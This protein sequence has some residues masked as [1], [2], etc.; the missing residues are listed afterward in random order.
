M[1]LKAGAALIELPK[2]PNAPD[3]PPVGLARLK[4]TTRPGS[5]VESPPSAIR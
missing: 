5:H 4:E 1:R 2:G 3:D